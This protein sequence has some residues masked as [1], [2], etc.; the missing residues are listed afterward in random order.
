MFLP[1]DLAQAKLLTTLKTWIDHRA[2]VANSQYLPVFLSTQAIVWYTVPF[3]VVL[4]TL[5]RAVT[6]VCHINVP[7]WRV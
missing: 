1:R 4:D 5:W 3:K 6:H 7:P 2:Q